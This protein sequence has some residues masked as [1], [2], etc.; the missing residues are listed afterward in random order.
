MRRTLIV[1]ALAFLASGCYHATINTGIAPGTQQIHQ[2]WAKSFVYGLVPP[3]TVEAMETCGPA[4]VARVETL[5]S[6]LNGLV[7]GLTFGIFTPM[8]ITVTCGQGEEDADLPEVTS[9]EE[10]EAALHGGT[11]F[12]VPLSTR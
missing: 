8:T 7:A 4:G 11:P 12:L 3:E 1:A 5:Q 2:P 10:F 6:F 9:R